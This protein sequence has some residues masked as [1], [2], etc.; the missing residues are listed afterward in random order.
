MKRKVSIISLFMIPIVLVIIAQGMVSVGMLKLN[1]A[2]TRL[3][4]NAVD[5]MSQTVENRK[6]I[7]EN[8]MLEQWSFLTNEKSTLI[9]QLKNVLESETI[10]PEEFLKN[11]D[12]QKRFLEDIFSYC[13]EELQ[14]NMVNGLFLVLGNDK[15]PDQA[16]EYLGFFV[17]DSDEY[18]QSENNTDLLMERGS[19]TLARSE[20]I[21]LDSSWTT[22]FSLAGNGVRAC[23]E[24]FYRPYIAAMENTQDRRKYLGYWSEPFVLEDH[25]MDSH[26]MITYSI[27]VSF[28]DAVIGV[29]GVE[30]G[31][32]N[33]EELFQV[34][35]LDTDQNAGYM[36]AI[37]L[38]NGH[39]RPVCGRGNLFEL[40]ES[41]GEE[42]SLL[43]TKRE[44]FFQVENA[45]I[46]VQKIY[47]TVHHMNLYSNHVP[48]DNTDW[49]LV[50]FKTENAIFGVGKNIFAS[51]LL[52]VMLGVLFG[53]VMVFVLVGRVTSPIARLVNSVRGGI[54]GIRGFRKSGI[55]E[56]DEI[57]EVVET[58]TEEQLKAEEKIQEE[59]EKYRM[60][61][62][63]SSDIFYTFDFDSGMLEVMNSKDA[64]GVWDCTSHPEYM[65]DHLVYPDDR[66]NLKEVRTGAYQ[67][68]QTEIRIRMPEYTEYQWFQISGKSVI[69]SNQKRRRLV[70]VIRNIN[71][72]KL[73]ELA[74]QKRETIDPVTGLYRQKQGLG[75][76][77]DR[78]KYVPEGYLLLLN[79]DNFRKMN[80]HFGLIFGDLV[81]EKLAQLLTEELKRWMNI[82]VRSGADEILIWIEGAD[83]NQIKSM[84]QRVKQDLRNLIHRDALNIAFF[85]GI[86]SA[87]KQADEEMLTQAATA[88]ERARHTGMDLVIYQEGWNQE[89]VSFCPGKVISLAWIREMNLVSLALN[90]F[91]KDGELSVLLDMLAD[92]MTESYHPEDIMITVLD[93]DYMAN[94]LEYQWHR[95]ERK[96]KLPEIARYGKEDLQLF[97][98]NCNL[99]S[100]QNLSAACCQ[101]ALFL[102]FI[103]ESQGIVIHMTDGGNYMG[104]ILMTGVDETAL[105]SQEQQKELKEIAML[106]Q[107]RLNRQHHDSS[108]EAKAEFL[109][110]M[111]HEIRTPMNGIMG[112]TEIALMTGQSQEKVQDCLK[113]I[114]NSSEYLLGLLNDILDMSKIESGRMQLIQDDFELTDLAENLYQLFAAR[115]AEKQLRYESDISLQHTG[116]YADELRINQVLINL[117][118]NAVKFTPEK[119]KIV[120]TIRELSSD[121]TGAD[122]F[123]SVKDNGIGISKE[124]QK[125]VFQSFEQ[126][127]T[128]NSSRSQGNGLGLAISSRLVRLMG[129][130][131]SLESEPGKGSEF[132]FTL[133]LEYRRN[134]E[135]SDYQKAET[136]LFDGS[137]VLVVEDN[138][139]NLEIIRTI[140]EEYHIQVD[141]AEDGEQ[142][143]KRM[144][145]AECGTYDLIF[146]DIMMPKMNGLE[147]TEAI[148]MIDREDCRSIPIVAMSANAFDEDVKKSMASG[149][150]GHLSKPLDMEKLQKTLQKYLKGT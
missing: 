134:Q 51:M 99:D 95:E 133:H 62:E 59:S 141:S 53:V 38:G 57:H 43:S 111:S 81:M 37:D 13:V 11:E 17:R 70:G 130:D 126:A 12:A 73:Q 69:D 65:D 61:V 75:M 105:L 56:I 10:E 131:I 82:G 114:K 45:Q 123:F 20:G 34:Q 23:D 46:G 118:G 1:G 7:L 9:Q 19:K 66:K 140:L 68:F 55:R 135:K 137:R 50:G 58:L 35:E 85:C 122:V 93:S 83:L 132:S 26:Q 54:E 30:V 48:Y 15:E 52:A 16:A 129:D 98:K 2:D 100:I 77:R 109:A 21:T 31:I 14:K 120:L 139:L 28:G 107:N 124:D 117:I 29:L 88:L 4:N 5:M 67:G 112:M 40:A 121:E 27:P 142:A 33:L 49:V 39:F 106:I 150:N 149:M 64:D 44:D 79:V 74:Y 8:K 76:I 24:F 94:M 125:K 127:D 144:Q 116:F 60:A 104:S 90:L 108:S 86:V 119:G 97:L 92:K 146:M 63:N 101:T 18:H 110:R 72:R 145:E 36:L 138:S 89:P 136:M 84:L 128:R 143:V 87:K 22:R 96:E 47:A 148:R 32:S 113:K 78:R 42:I 91:D 71:E 3:E 41:S 80:K 115:M 102:P 103:K 6:V 25:Y 147:A